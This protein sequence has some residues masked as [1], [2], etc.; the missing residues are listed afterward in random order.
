MFK[1]IL[2]LTLLSSFVLTSSAASKKGIT[3]LVVP[4][5]AKTIQIAQDV[6][7]LNPVLLVS[8]QQ[9]EKLL[10]LYAWN[11]DGW[12]DVSMEDYINGAFFENPP[13]HT[14]IIEPANAP[15]ADALVPDGTWCE[16]GNRLTTTDPRAMIHLLGRHFNFQNRHWKHFAETQGFALEDLNP[17]LINIYWWQ[18]PGKR[19]SFNAEADMKNWLTLDI[20]PPEPIEP[21]VV[22]EEPEPVAPAE[23]PAKEMIEKPVVKKVIEVPPTI[24]LVEKAK[25]VAEKT[26]TIEEIIGTLGEAAPETKPT[27]IDPFLATEIPAAEV[28]LPPTE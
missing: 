12:I 21:I 8:Y 15:S 20:T 6:A 4:R 17:E 3:M 18:H 27:A 7:Q 1:K 25:P 9:T 2:L 10:K 13:Q 23:I 16:S 19:S 14:I 5:D 11:G 22:E 28:V 24:E 26:P